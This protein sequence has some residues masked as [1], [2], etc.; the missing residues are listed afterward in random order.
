MVTARV[1]TAIRISL[2]QASKALASPK[3]MVM[4]TWMELLALQKKM[5]EAMFEPYFRVC[6]DAV[7]VVIDNSFKRL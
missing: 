1:A 2:V 5:I 4:N 6:D 7:K 3:G